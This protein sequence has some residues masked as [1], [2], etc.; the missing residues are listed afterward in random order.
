MHVQAAKRAAVTARVNR[1]KTMNT[2]FIR[3]NGTY[4]AQGSSMKSGT[5]LAI[6]ERDEYYDFSF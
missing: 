5:V 1:R 2:I 6:G 4:V 3:K